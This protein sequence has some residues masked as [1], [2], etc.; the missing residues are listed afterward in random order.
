MASTAHLVAASRVK[1]ERGSKTQEGLEAASTDVRDA[2]REL[3][4]AA[5]NASEACSNIQ[6]FGLKLAHQ[7]FSF[8][9]FQCLRAFCV[10]GVFFGQIFP[11][12]FSVYVHFVDGRFV[13]FLF[14]KGHFATVQSYVLFTE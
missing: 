12:F 1:A 9:S 10:M 6:S 8:H 4:K 7:N 14:K 5:K 3:V 2:T 13:K 11:P